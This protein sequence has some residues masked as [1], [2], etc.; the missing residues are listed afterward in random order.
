MDRQEVCFLVLLDL[1]SAFDTIDHKAI[2]EVLEHQ[3]GVTDKALEWIKSF[4]SNRKQRVDLDNNF[5][6]VCDVNYGVPQGS[7]LGPILLLLYISQL[8][9]IIDRHL[10]SSHGYAD[11]TQL[12]VSFRPDCVAN[13]RSTL[14]AL[15]GC[16]SNVR[17]W[18]VSHKLLFK[19]TKTELLVIGTPQQ[20][21]KIEIG[22]VNV[23]G[24]QI[25]SVDSVRN[26]GSWFD[27]YMSMSVHVGKMCSKAFGGLYKIRQIRKCL[28]IDTTKSL[29]H[30]FVTSHMDYCNALLVGIPQYQVQRIQRVLNA[31]ARLIYHCPRFSHITPVLI[32]LHWLPVKY[33]A[34]FKIALLVY[35]ALN[36]MAP[37]YISEL[38]IPK[39]SSDRWTLR[40]DDQGLLHIM[41]PEN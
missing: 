7:C 13:Q 36:N 33:R 39:P 28:S 18:L 35:K 21:S 17:G 9:D 19:D 37:I 5:S 32:A 14:A 30:A 27:K 20:L 23:G 8:Y 6:E 29:I 12:Y 2:I 22:S 16:I 1:S 10:P 25:K 3:F 4:L 34:E 41:H 11:D 26:L 31:A 15:E 40:S 24:F 38:L